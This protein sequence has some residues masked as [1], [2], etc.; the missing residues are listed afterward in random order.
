MNYWLMKSEPTTFGIDH[1]IKCT[2]DT[3]HWEGVR[4]YQARNF[5]RD[6]MKIHDRAFFYHSNCETPG[7]VGIMEIAR[8][9]HPD[10]TALDLNSKYYDPK[11]TR[12]NPRWAMVSV[13]FLEKFKNTIPL[14]LLKTYSELQGMVLLKPGNRLS[15]TPVTEKE[16]TFILSLKKELKNT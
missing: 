2:N 14:S 10:L 5:M 3:D 7:I 6:S 12:D 9:S 11:S 1:L 13:R 16:W 4:N 15:I 8:E